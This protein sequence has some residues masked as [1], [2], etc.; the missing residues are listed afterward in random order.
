[1]RLPHPPPRKHQTL[2][3]DRS[4]AIITHPGSEFHLGQKPKLG[5]RYA[6]NHTHLHIIFCRSIIYPCFIFFLSFAVPILFLQ[7]KTQ[8][9][10]K[11]FRCFSLVIA[12]V[13]CF[14]VCSTFYFICYLKI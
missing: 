2:E 3:M 6:D 9:D 5:G 4:G 1:M 11:Y 7:S 12:L 10:Q 13:F 14:L 8:K